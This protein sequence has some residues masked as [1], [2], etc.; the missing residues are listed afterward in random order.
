MVNV[1]KSAFEAFIKSQNEIIEGLK[2]R[3][4]QF[5]T[6]YSVLL[7]ENESLSKRVAEFEKNEKSNVNGPKLFSDLFKKNKSEN[8]T[9][10]NIINAIRIEQTESEKKNKETVDEIS[11]TIGFD[12]NKIKFIKRLKR[13]DTS[14]TS[15]PILV[16]LSDK[17]DKFEILKK[18]NE[19][20]KTLIA[21]RNELNGK[22]DIQESGFR[23]CKYNPVNVDQMSKNFQNISNSIS[24]LKCWYTIASSLDNKM[25]IFVSEL[26]IVEPNIALISETWFRQNSIT[27]IR[28]YNLFKKNRAG[29]G[30]GVCIYVKKGIEVFDVIIPNLIDD[31]VEHVL[32]SIHNGEDKIL[33][34]CIYRPPESSNEINVRI[35][36]LLAEA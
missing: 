29:R 2:S 21:K 10:T 20:N 30:G 12:K 9:E 23:Y 24:R 27:M 5:E 15:T 34:G 4:S 32:C 7:V 19:L 14:V 22:N 17:N 6:K 31:F 13:K 33:V 8:S 36:L 25:D 26:L 1:Q 16:E 11:N 28:G 3:L 35:N 18:A